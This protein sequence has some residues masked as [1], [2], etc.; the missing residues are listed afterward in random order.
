MSYI[1]NDLTLD[2]TVSNTR[3]QQNFS[4]LDSVISGGLTQNNL[5]PS[6]LIPSSNLAT[7]NVEETLVLSAPAASFGTTTGNKAILYLGG[8]GVYT[9]QG[10]HLDAN[11]TGG[12]T[13]AQ[14]RVLNGATF[15][16]LSTLANNTPC[17]PGTTTQTVLAA[18]S[19]SITA[20]QLIIVDV[21]TAFTVAPTGGAI[22]ITLRVTRS[23]Q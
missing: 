20:P 12:T 8:T 15:G 10:I 22:A 7:P 2:A 9:I 18:L 21:T 17:P 14:I 23:L 13:T 6:A 19:S 4:S 11:V 5:S 3:I 1:P 16:T